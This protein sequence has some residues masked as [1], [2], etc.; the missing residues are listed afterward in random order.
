MTRNVTA[1]LHKHG[2]ISGLHSRKKTACGKDL[3]W[4]GLN[5]YHPGDS[6]FYYLRV[7]TES[8][9]RFVQLC[10]LKVSPS[11]YFIS[12]ISELVFKS[13]NR[14][15]V[16]LVVTHYSHTFRVNKSIIYNHWWQI[17]T[18]S[19]SNYFWLESVKQRAKVK[20]MLT[21][22]NYWQVDGLQCICAE[23][24]TFKQKQVFST[25]SWYV[26]SSRISSIHTFQLCILFI[27]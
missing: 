21:R 6:I 7:L 11:T 15:N 20:E 3:T 9:A 24:F 23:I 1:H 8:C 22:D 2:Y 4:L 16:W 27:K 18:F 26:S 14:V 13:T 5:W 25:S 12:N 17:T 10:V 19:P